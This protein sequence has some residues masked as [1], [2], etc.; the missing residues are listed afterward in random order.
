M[1]YTVVIS[2]R[3]ARE[4]ADAAA[5]WAGERSVD[6]AER[7]Y[8]GIRQAIARLADSPDARPLAPEHIAFDRELRELHYGLGSRATHRAIFTTVGKTV[9]VLSVRHVARG[10]LRPDDL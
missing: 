3:A 2:E 6:Q 7:W 8:D 5:W 1:T 4:I 9:V 10:P